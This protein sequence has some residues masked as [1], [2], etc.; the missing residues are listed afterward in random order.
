MARQNAD[1]TPIGHPIFAQP[2][3]T[4]DP[5][6]FRIRRPSDD[7]AYRT[8][9]QLNAESKLAPLPFPSPRGGAEPVFTLAEALGANGAD[10]VK[11]IAAAGQLV[12]HSVGDTGSVRGPQNQSPTRCWPTSTRKRQRTCRSSS[13]TSVT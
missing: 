11:R 6:R 13:S 12:F 8:I 3:P 10:I 7:A 1:P 5:T 2:R 9:D 4:A